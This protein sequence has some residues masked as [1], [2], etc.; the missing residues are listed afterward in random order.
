MLP[1]AISCI[2]INFFYV[3]QTKSNVGN[4]KSNN[5]TSTMDSSAEDSDDDDT[6]EEKETHDEVS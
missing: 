4:A 1:A 5:N 3:R 6:N 2:K